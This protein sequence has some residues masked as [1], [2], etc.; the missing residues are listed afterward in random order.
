MYAEFIPTSIPHAYWSSGIEKVAG[1]TF[2]IR[3]VHTKDDNYSATINYNLKQ[4]FKNILNLKEKQ[5][6]NNNNMIG[7]I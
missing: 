3:P 2:L 4:S 7:I 5:S 6:T 1:E